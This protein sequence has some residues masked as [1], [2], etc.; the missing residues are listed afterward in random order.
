M[1]NG[2][3]YGPR[4]GGVPDEEDKPVSPCR[5]VVV[6]AWM[7]AVTAPGAMATSQPK[8]HCPEDGAGDGPVLFMLDFPG[9]LC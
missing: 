3:R 2:E 7:G 1:R 6:A 4:R 5:K 9:N 8:I